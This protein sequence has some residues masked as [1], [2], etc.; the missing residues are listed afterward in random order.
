MGK[1]Q[2]SVDSQL[3]GLPGPYVPHVIGTF[4]TCSRGAIHWSLTDMDGGYNLGG[5]DFPHH[6]PQPSQPMV[7]RFPPKGP[8][9]S[10]VIQSQRK[11]K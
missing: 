3:L 8:A 9:R 2:A 10:Q 6:T 1:R 4:N 11:L 5:V 7:L